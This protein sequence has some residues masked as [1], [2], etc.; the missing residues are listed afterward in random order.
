LESAILA[1]KG[2]KTIHRSAVTGRIVTAA[3]AAAHPK[4]TETEH[5]PARRPSAP[6]K[7]K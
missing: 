4:T 3:Y 6:K 7:G 5:R 1:T 2:S